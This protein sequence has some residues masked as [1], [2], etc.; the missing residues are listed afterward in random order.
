MGQGGQGM[1]G[2]N[3]DMMME[4][5]DTMTPM[6]AQLTFL[7]VPLMAAG[8]KGLNLFR[9]RSDADY[10]TVGDI[11]ETNYWKLA[12][13]VGDYAA[14]SLWSVAFVTQALSMAGIAVEANIWMFTSVLPLMGGL[15]G[16]TYALLMGLGWN[17]AYTVTEDSATSS[18]DLEFA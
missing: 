2:G 8:T 10:Y 3:G 6:M 9:W 13:L 15:V 18:A 12:N 1:G 7:M 5:E 16:F 11:T 4:E 17:K 14:L